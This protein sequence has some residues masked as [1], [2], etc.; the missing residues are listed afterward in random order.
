MDELS[1][2][3]PVEEIDG[4]SDQLQFLTSW[5]VTILLSFALH[6]GLTLLAGVRRHKAS[7]VLRLILG[8]AYQ[9]SSWVAPY[10][11]SN[12]SLGNT[13]SRRQQLLTFWAMFLLHHL[14][15]PDNISAFSL[16]DNVLSGREALS[17]ITKVVAAGYAL[18][19][20]VYMSGDGGALVPASIIIFTI[21]VAK[22]VERAVALWQGHLG[23]IRI[24]G[25]E[26][27]ASRFF[28]SCDG[29]D[30]GSLL[31]MGRDH[32]LDDEQ[33][34]I[35]AHDML[36]FCKRA[37]ADSSVNT[38]L[39]DKHAM[40]DS[41]VITESPDKH[42]MVDSPVNTESP[43]KCAMADSSVNTESPDND[44]ELGTSRKIFTLSWENMSK[45]VEM[46]L[47]LMYDIL[48]TK[49]AIVHTWHGYAIR[50]T[51]PLAIVAATVL[52]GFH[53]KEGQ[54]RHDVIITYT[55][56]VATF[57]LDTRWLLRALVDLDARF[58]TVHLATSCRLVHWEM[59]LATVC[60]CV[61]G[62]WP[63]TPKGASKGSKQIQKVVRHCWPSQPAA[64]VHS[65]EHR[66]QRRVGEDWIRDK[67]L[68]LTY[69]VE[70]GPYTTEGIMTFWGRLT[71]KR[72][73]VKHTPHG[74]KPKFILAF[75]REFQED[76]LVWH[77]AT[78]IFLVCCSD[79][80]VTRD[81]KS[82]THAQAIDAMS[83]HLMFLMAVRRYML[84][85]IALRSLY[86]ATLNSLQVLWEKKEWDKE[87]ICF[88][89]TT[90]EE[91]LARMLAKNKKGDDEWGLGKSRTRLVSDGANIALELLKADGLKM[92]KLL[93]LV[94]KIWVDKLL[95]AAT[96]CSRESH[97]RQLGRGGDLITIVW[98]MV[99]HVGPFEI[100]KE[101]PDEK[102]ESS[103]TEDPGDGTGD[104]INDNEDPSSAEDLESQGGAGGGGWP[105]PPSWLHPPAMP[106]P[107]Q[108][109]WCPPQ[110]MHPPCDGGHMFPWPWLQAPW[111]HPTTYLPTFGDGGHIMPSRPVAG[112][113]PPSPPGAPR[114]AALPPRKDMPPRT[115]QASGEHKDGKP[116]RRRKKAGRYATLYP[117]D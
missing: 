23:N 79:E 18:Y 98:I 28:T 50:F 29:L 106:Q 115:P 67:I 25:K 49:A 83:E 80:L 111:D 114:P 14:G 97:A 73:K 11:L 94:F 7:G 92:P 104:W 4:S 53:N 74:E 59:A 42:A 3:P 45:V 103:D 36:R 107:M 43:D 9:L 33:A 57:L 27:K 75:G 109:Q 108:P 101:G 47:S 112:A 64:R 30:S 93:E 91:K 5:E 82:V 70:D 44:Y 21:G 61:S 85:G 24:S 58:P 37:M 88:S 81:V 95:Y 71:A 34:L 69:E 26:K 77:I 1:L 105:H 31:T 8:L 110:P 19:K 41:S 89:R 51:S 40:A 90:A 113:P 76:I 68:K 48:Y 15:G 116:K 102:E 84:P 46:E 10:A 72:Y 100:G 17:V 55:L 66:M 96:R 56:L 60:C 52:F 86:E 78:K 20:Y 32:K 62:F 99:E 38:E 117:V 39:P 2:T 22:Y 65:K 12:L 54:S 6:L 35:V 87:D 16:E 63:A 13:M